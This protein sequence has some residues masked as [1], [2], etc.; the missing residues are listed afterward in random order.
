MR[1]KTKFSWEMR[2]D[3]AKRWQMDT[4]KEKENKKD[5]KNKNQNKE[6]NMINNEEHKHKW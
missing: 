1:K 2:E 4:S 6:K 5:K 3:E